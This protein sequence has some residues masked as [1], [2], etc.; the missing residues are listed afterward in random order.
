MIDLHTH[1]LYSDGADSPE[2]LVKRAA[3]LGLVALALTD[4]DTVAGVREAL[5]A[6]ARY[7]V[8]V[9]PGVELSAA[10][11]TEMHILGYYIDIDCPALTAACEKAATVRAERQA[12]TVQK[13]RRMGMDVTLDEVRAAA[14][15][16]ILCGAHIA[17][18]LVQKGYVPT[19]AEAFRRYLGPG[20]PAFVNRQALTPKEAIGVIR[21]AGGI[22]VLAHLNRMRLP[23]RGVED[24]LDELIPEGL[25]GVEGYYSEYTPAEGERYRAMAAARGLTVTAGSDYHGANKP[26]VPLGMEPILP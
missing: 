19:V 8:P 2:T 9:I 24:V 3:K 5:A 20:R 26:H 6:G 4:H 22:A 17:G 18:I 14:G 25:S 7:G 10:F 15:T 16:N 13:L 11:P 1:S 21:A 23:D 12:E